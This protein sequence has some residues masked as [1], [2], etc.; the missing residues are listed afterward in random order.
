VVKQ[1]LTVLNAEE[2]KE[3]EIVFNI[4]EKGDKFYV[5]LAG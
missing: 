1:V 3:G 5:I 4:D 2:A